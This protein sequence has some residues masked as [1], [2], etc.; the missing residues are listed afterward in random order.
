MKPTKNARDEIHD[1]LE[2]MAWDEER[3][4][5]ILS[6]EALY[7]DVERFE[8]DPYWFAWLQRE[9]PER[10]LRMQRKLRM[11]QRV[12]HWKSQDAE[13]KRDELLLNHRKLFIVSDAG[14]RGRSESCKNG[15]Q[16][17]EIYQKG[18]QASAAQLGF[19]LSPELMTAFSHL[20]QAE[21]EERSERLLAL[22]RAEKGADVDPS[23]YLFPD[24]PRQCKERSLEELSDLRFAGYLAD[25][26]GWLIDDPHLRRFL[27][28]GKYAK[29]TERTPLELDLEEM[30][31]ISLGRE[32]DF[33]EM[34]RNLLGSRMPLSPLDQECLGTVLLA[35]NFPVERILPDE[36]PFKET[37]AWLIQRK[38]EAG[39][40]LQVQLKSFT[41][42]KRVYAAMIGENAD[43]KSNFLL[44]NLPNQDRKWLMVQMEAGMAHYE[45]SFRTSAYQ[46]QEFVTLF[47]NRIHP[48][49][50]RSAAPRACALL[51]EVKEGK[52]FRTLNSQ[53]EQALA[54][55]KPVEAARLAVKKP[56]EAVRRLAAM[57]SLASREEGREILELVGACAHNV[58]T[59]VLLN[60]KCAFDHYEFGTLKICFPQGKTNAITAF[61]DTKYRIDPELT[62][63]ASRMLREAVIRRLSAKEPLGAVFIAPELAK[64][65][66][67]FAGREDSKT[68]R[69]LARGSRMAV[70]PDAEYLRFFVYKKYSEPIFVDLSLSFL[71]ENGR[72][73]SQCSWTNLK[74]GSVAV[75]SGDGD[76]CVDG[77]S[78]FVD[79]DLQK[80]NQA[81][82]NIRYILMNV[83]SYNRVPFCKMDRC[84]AG[85]MVRKGMVTDRLPDG[86]IYSRLTK[87]EQEKVRDFHGEVFE[88]STVRFRL[89][90]NAPK[91]VSLPL[92]YDVRE[93]EV[94]WADLNLDR[95]PRG[96]IRIHN[97]NGNVKP[98]PGTLTIENLHSQLSALCNSV[99]RIRK[100]DLKELAELNVEARGGRIVPTREEADLVIAEDGDLTPF[101][102]DVITKDW[103]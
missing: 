71:D 42:V 92:I 47:W 95:M 69:K 99:V 68:Y 70:S 97:T 6:A 4:E 19:L 46:E 60:A 40:D 45:N 61:R 29:H 96:T 63:G 41:D 55:E 86:R 53:I 23:N 14:A 38:R 3:I 9:H 93:Q 51:K 16:P 1:T 44:D 87:A 20:P 83:F 35:K 26:F 33:Y 49:K 17:A 43:L 13:A 89:D 72:Y 58:D 76:N 30:E 59:T 98:Y 8:Y 101:M 66:V 25:L 67:P 90:L 57:L 5:P 21:F 27:E 7:E 36:I 62:E 37:L 10:Y 56:G 11:E 84:F 91:R 100:P 74:M 94:I 28:L 65:H 24:F 80:L 54:E 2:E 73:V 22:L 32:E 52:K 82:P 85:L 39:F 78:E 15:R 79:V 12:A 75:H 102:S 77:L 18:L 103:L 34:A 88:P 81:H 48:E 50:Y 31:T 64:I